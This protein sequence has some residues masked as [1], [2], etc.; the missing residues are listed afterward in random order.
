MKKSLAILISASLLVLSPGP[1]A[2]ALVASLGAQPGANAVPTSASP[3]SVSI[4]PVSGGVT[5]LQAPLNR[6]GAPGLSTV[7]PAVPPGLAPVVPVRTG[8]PAALPAAARIPAAGPV[9]G[10]AGLAL[11]VSPALSRR[12]AAMGLGNAPSAVG[13]RHAAAAEGRGRS[14]RTGARSLLSALRLPSLLR[15]G[16]P[17][18]AEAARTTAEEDFLLHTGAAAKASDS[19]GPVAGFRGRAGAGPATLGA[20]RHARGAAETGT[21]NAVRG[22]RRGEAARGTQVRSGNRRIARRMGRVAGRPAGRLVLHVPDAASTVLQIRPADGSRV[23]P[24]ASEGTIRKA[25]ERNG[26]AAF[27]NGREEQGNTHNDTALIN[28]RGEERT[29]DLAVRREYRSAYFPAGLAALSALTFGLL[30]AVPAA[31]SGILQNPAVSAT[32]ISAAMPAFGIVETV[33][34]AAATAAAASA[35]L[36][37]A[38]ALWE[39]ALFA[40]AV[41]RGR[42]VPDEEFQRLAKGELLR[43]GLHPSVA[44]SLLGTGPGRGIMRVYRPQNRFA[45]FAFAF[46]AGGIVYVRPEIVRHPWLFRWVI[47]HELMHYQA[48]GTRAPPR[49]PSGLLRR[50]AR[51]VLGE[52]QGRL[53]EFR[54]ISSLSSLRIPIL[55]R[56]LQEARVSLRLPTSFDA[57]IIHPGNHEVRNPSTYAELSRG[58]ARVVKLH[59]RGG[60]KSGYRAADDALIGD[61]NKDAASVHASPDSVPASEGV[62]QYLAREANEGRFRMIVYPRSFGAVPNEG[63]REARRLQVALRQI[64]SVQLLMQR[65]GLMGKAGFAEG[66]AEARQLDRLS[67][68]ILGVAAGNRRGA[69]QQ[70]HLLEDLMY[71]LARG[72][73]QGLQPTETFENLYRS[74]RNSGTVLLPFAPG[75]SGMDTVERVLRYWRAKDGGRFEVSRVD[76]PEGGHVV[77]AGKMEPRA[78]IWL[79]PKNGRRIER[80]AT[81]AFNESAQVQEYYLRD[82]GYD[83]EDIKR[84]RQA[85]VEV[86]HVFGAEDGNRIFASVH[87]RYAKALQRYGGQAG[88]RLQ[89]SRGGYQW[90]LVQSGS[91]QNVPQTWKLRI[92][93]EGGRIYDIDTGLDTSHPDFAD[94]LMES[95][96]F[97]DQGP[98]DWIGHG[99]HKAGIS[100]ANGSVY[101]G[102]APR[103]MGRMGKVFAQFGASDGDIMAAAV[104]ALEWGADVISLS[105]GSPGTVDSELAEFISNL[106]RRRNSRGHFPIVTASAGN[107]GPFN[108]TRSQPAVGKFVDLVGSAT[109]SLDDGEPEMS[110]FSSVGPTV[111]RRFSKRRYRMP[112]GL[113]ALGGDVTTPPDFERMPPE[114]RDVYEH[115]IESVKSKDKQPSPA[116]APDGKHTRMSGTSMSN[117]M[118]AGIALLVKQAALRVLKTGTAAHRFFFEN[119]PF[120]VNLILMRSAKD[121]RVPIHFQ[122]GGFVDA[123][124]AVKLAARSFGGEFLSRPRRAGRAVLRAL[125]F[126][127][128]PRASTRAGF[129]D[130]APWDWISRAKAVWELE[131]RVY[132]ESEAAKEEAIRGLRERAGPVGNPDAPIESPHADAVSKGEVTDAANRA[133]DKRFNELRAEVMPQLYKALQDDVWLVRMYA[134]F[135]LMNLRAPEAVLSLAEAALGD[136]DGRVRQTAFLA[137][138]ETPS[139]AA[140]EA[141]RQAVLDSRPDVGIYAAYALARHGDLSGLSRIVAETKSADKRIRFTAVW[142]L[143]Q[144]GR[145]APPEAADALAGRVIDAVERGNIKHLSVASLTEMASMRPQSLTNETILNLLASA[146]P[147]NFVLTGTIFKFFQPAVRSEEVRLR[148]R[149]KPL[150]DDILLFIHRHKAAL[151]RP[152][153]LSDLVRLLADALE[154]S[155]D[156]PTPPPSPA[157]LG[158]PGVDPNRGGVHLIVE[159]PQESEGGPAIQSFQDFRGVRGGQDALAKAAGSFGLEMKTLQRYQA[160][161]QVAMPASR[162]L[163]INVPDAEVMAFT[164]EMEA[165]GYRVHR[166][167]PMYKLLHETGPLTGMPEARESRG[168]TGK[169]VLVAY[170]DEGGD[171]EHPAFDNK[172]IKHKRNFSGDGG[173][174][175]VRKESDSHGSHGMGIVGAQSVEGSPYVGMAPGVDFAVIKVLGETGGSEATV[176][177]GMEYAAS[178]VKDPLKTPL[179]LNLSLGGPGSPDSPI[180]RLVNR[181]RLSNIGVIVAAGNS[182]P[183]EGTVSSPANAAL[184]TAVGAVDKRKQL[185]DYSSR[186]RRGERGVRRVNFGGGIFFNRPNIYEIVSTLS[187]FLAKKGGGSPNAVEWKGKPLYH[188]MSGTSMAA[189]HETGEQA[190]QIERMMQVMDKKLGRLPDGYL[191]WIENLLDATAERLE[192]YGDHEIGAG[193]TDGKKAL[194]ALDEALLDPD[195]VIE[196]AAELKRR[197]EEEIARASRPEKPSRGFGWLRRLSFI[198]R[199]SAGFVIATLTLLL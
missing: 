166:A 75:E 91:L 39:M 149:E 183:M 65:R 41:A 104:D 32:G 42:Y 147:Q 187:T 193:L 174:G 137:I 123:L 156:Q 11:P 163:W 130:K 20:P 1:R 142:L 178:L 191:F 93:G 157:G 85:G 176:M 83:D 180:G 90:H 63:S 141:L 144:L 145:R 68:R 27:I 131:D 154:V 71:Q 47:K 23:S 124:A 55:D 107:S 151:S 117:P 92:R 175:E 116:D 36:L 152:G 48:Q 99:S 2:W 37:A 25:Q 31:V 126:A 45:H 112:L 46:T 168:L 5:G 50:L 121:M 160:A 24:A 81:R 122:E 84:L 79:H 35:L 146:G 113:T 150:R 66:S 95:V 78:E 197:A 34:G 190:V 136:S 114:R 188:A 127:R 69:T 192:G 38:Y 77:V 12:A 105:L 103:A 18:G 158:V 185:A 194:A 17:R 148:M 73:L 43:W 53:G 76:L 109:K 64:D 161:L 106:T 170:I 181:L 74:L 101:K 49:R 94:R 14:L 58:R 19:E 7:L 61:E 119:V 62:N 28:G 21:A 167:A 173:V 13:R 134:A 40:V 51:H 70:D 26:A 60:A 96:D 155:L 98:E 115:G 128:A 9:A 97:V 16:M 82:A 30:T 132:R 195:K 129:S 6:S 110:F 179:L 164:T 139:Y 102:M 108:R 182:G 87:R 10:A 88:F 198:P 196:E 184:A 135:A 143:G 86:R 29:S 140:D 189:P 171:T 169:G 138:A 162:S 52:L 8:A 56:V 133:L 4:F 15:H 199:L 165:R 177:A 67:R 153:A 118:I 89:P 44:A 57:L 111:D 80:T 100:Y 59:T 159:L 172:R 120:A 72:R 54:P 22:D 186:G 125:G 33:F 3:V